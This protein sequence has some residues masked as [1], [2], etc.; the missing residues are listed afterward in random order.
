MKSNELN[1]PSSIFNNSIY[2]DWKIS[3]FVNVNQQLNGTS[4]LFIKVNQLPQNGSCDINKQNGTALSTYF[5]IYCSNWI[6]RDGSIVKY[7][8]F[9]NF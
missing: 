4:Y 5:I 9:S 1:I 3:F 6:D 2:L 8:Y 7:E